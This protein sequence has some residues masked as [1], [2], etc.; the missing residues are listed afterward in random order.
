MNVSVTPEL[1]RFVKDLV[2]T[3]R[4][5]SASEVIR[6]GLRLLELAERRRLLEKAIIE[7]LTPEEEGQLAAELLERVRSDIRAKIQEGFDS[8][9]C[10]DSVDGEEFFSRWRERIA[11]D[12]V[13]HRARQERAR[14]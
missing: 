3:G 8:L 13:L 2:R 1:E 14:G 12:K 9:D 7:G 10:G 6:D 4:Y 5:H 11:A